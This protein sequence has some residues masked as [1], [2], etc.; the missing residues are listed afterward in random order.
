MKAK[1]LGWLLLLFCYAG[2]S[3]IKG[4]IDHQ[5]KEFYLQANIRLDHKFFGYAEPAITSVKLICFSIFTND[6]KDNP[7]K[8]SLGAF[9]ETNGLS[10]GD[11]IIYL[12]NVG[13]FAKMKF[14][15]AN[16]IETIFYFQRNKIVFDWIKSV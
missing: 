3:Q 13:R 5:T 10:A 8:C 9:Y 2:F 6:V 1:L 11:K 14:I 15:A 4:H 16:G 12:V 7:H